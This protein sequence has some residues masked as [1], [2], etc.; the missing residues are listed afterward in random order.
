MLPLFQKFKSSFV[1]FNF[2]TYFLNVSF[3]RTIKNLSMAKLEYET[4]IIASFSSYQV[5]Q[6]A[7]V[8]MKFHHEEKS[9]IQERVPSY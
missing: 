7:F 5:F 6:M 9:F 1:V 2:I 4:L 3:C 8:H